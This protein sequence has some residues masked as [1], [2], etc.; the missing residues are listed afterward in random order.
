MRPRDHHYHYNYHRHNQ[1]KSHHHHYQNQGNIILIT[2]TT[3]DYFIIIILNLIIGRYLSWG[4]EIPVLSLLAASSLRR[5]SSL[6]FV[7]MLCYYS[8]LF[9]F[10]SMLCHYLGKLSFVVNF[11]ISCCYHGCI[12][13]SL[14]PEV[15]EAF[16][17]YLKFKVSSFYIPYLYSNAPLS[18]SFVCHL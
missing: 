12:C 14:T 15:V 9:P 4:R 7:V 10:V 1:G 17:C 2:I 16:I 18:L 13:H 3:I 11:I 6:S 5:V 8:G